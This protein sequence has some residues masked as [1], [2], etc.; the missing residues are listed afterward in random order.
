LRAG[1]N[2]SPREPSSTWTELVT[3]LLHAG[4]IRRHGDT[5]MPTSAFILHRSSAQKDAD[6]IQSRLEQDHAARC[7]VVERVLEARPL[8]KGT[9]R[10]FIDVGSTFVPLIQ[11]L[12]DS[13]SRRDDIHQLSVVTAS[14]PV[15][16]EVM[17]HAEQHRVDLHLIGGPVTARHSC[18][19]PADTAAITAGLPPPLA[20][21]DLAFLGASAVDLA[22][23]NVYS[24]VTDI[25]ITKQWAAS[26]SRTVAL[27]VSQ[28]KLRRGAANERTYATLLRARSGQV[29]LRSSI[30]ETSVPVTIFS[31]TIAPV[32]YT[33][34]YA[35]CLIPKPPSS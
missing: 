4:V 27:L 20:N 5:W 15:A 12:L 19:G 6:G 18:T 35:S 1:S 21:P 10:I 29:E 31:D 17:M 7:R 28:S 24:D 33:S 9:P 32:H 34:T 3:S 23:G 11:S 14:L 25:H 2:V 26:R 8:A 13:L 16:V 22:S 30:A